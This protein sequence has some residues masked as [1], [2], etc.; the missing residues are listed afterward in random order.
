MSENKKKEVKPVTKPF[1]KG[2]PTDENT[3]KNAAAHFGMMVAMAVMSFLVCSMTGVDSLILRLLMNGLIIFVILMVFY[4][5]GI[6]H[7]SD[8]V[9]RGEIIYQRD[10]RNLPVSNSERKLSYHP[11]KGFLNGLIGTIPFLIFAI[12]FAFM[13][14][15]QVTGAGVLPSWTGVYLRR[16]EIGGPLAAYTQPVGLAFTDIL[17]ILVRICV[18]PFISLVGA[19]NSSGMLLVERLSPVILLLPALA[20]GIGYLQGVSIRT[21]VHTEIAENK[22]KR[23]RRERK[24]RKARLNN[25]KPKGPEQLN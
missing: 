25:L 12:V 10:E 14:E 9:A 8:A 23:A 19:E 7:G 11:A 3:W 21:K 15:R 17:R 13:A 18:M 24:A 5:R 4:Q 22:K 1:A 16:T 6:N 2:S 20:S